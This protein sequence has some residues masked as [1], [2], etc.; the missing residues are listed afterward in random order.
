MW[1]TPWA[2]ILRSLISG[3]LAQL[4]L[5]WHSKSCGGN[6]FG[7]LLLIPYAQHNLIHPKLIRV[8]G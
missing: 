7:T 1:E 4:T 2:L 3:V 8:W 6:A 5:A